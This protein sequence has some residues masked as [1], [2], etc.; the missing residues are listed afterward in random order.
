MNDIRSDLARSTPTTVSIRGK[1]LVEAMGTTDIGS[2]FY[3]VVMGRDPSDAEATIVNA[4]L[5]GLVEHGLTPSAL[6][7]RLTYLGAPESLQGAVASGLLGVG[8]QFVGP[9]EEVSRVLQVACAQLDGEVEEERY[10]GV[11]QQIVREFRDRRAAIPGVGH[12]VHRPEDPRAVRLFGLA[13]ELGVAGRHARLQ[14]AIGEAADAA[15][16][17]HLPINVTGAIGAIV[18]DLGVPWQV[19][20]GFP[21]VSRAVGLIAHIR[22]ELDT[23]IARHVWHEVEALAQGD[24]AECT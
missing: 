4:I 22:E 19:A 23:P 1:D 13:D 11:A 6:A 3:Y 12:P 14:R 21:L 16:G 10:S 9:V 7:A 8:S 24:V 17:R 5:V 20:R 15:L 18:S 2:F